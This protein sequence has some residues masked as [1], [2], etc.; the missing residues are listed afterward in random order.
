MY[1]YSYKCTRT[2][3]IYCM[4][5]VMHRVLVKSFVR[6]C[7]QV[8]LIALCVKYILRV[9]TRLP[10]D[11]AWFTTRSEILL[12]FRDISGSHHVG[13]LAHFFINSQSIVYYEYSVPSVLYYIRPCYYYVIT[14]HYFSSREMYTTATWRVFGGF[15]YF[16]H[17]STNL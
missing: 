17:C 11:F 14:M 3:I 12:L 5:C 9:C 16:L 1:V 7:T 8:D 6:A 15:L 13:T 2:R 4:Y 10:S